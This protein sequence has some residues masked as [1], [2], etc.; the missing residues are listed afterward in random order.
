MSQSKTNPSISRFCTASFYLFRDEKELLLSFQPIYQNNPKEKGVRDI[1][2]VNK[3]EF[4]PYGGL[5][6]QAFPQ[7][8]ENF[9]NSQHPHS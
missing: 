5:F 1:I 8:N 3:K 9:I 2:N 4:E 7:F 6:H